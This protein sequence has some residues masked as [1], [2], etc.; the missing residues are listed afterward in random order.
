MLNQAEK[1]RQK[2]DLDRARTLYNAAIEKNPNDSEAVA[3]LAGIA[4]AQHD[5]P[6]ARTQYQRVMQINPNYR[7]ARIG[8]ADV[9]WDSGNKDGATKMYK[10]IVDGHAEGTYPARVKQ[11]SEGGG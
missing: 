3:G 1:A 6:T 10:E 11:R 5:L 4:Y 7:P 8:L 2:G 9:E